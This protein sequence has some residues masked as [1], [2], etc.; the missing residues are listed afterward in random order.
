MLCISILC[1]H[2]V[3]VAT[4]ADLDNVDKGG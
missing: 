4:G 2:L 1:K 3:S